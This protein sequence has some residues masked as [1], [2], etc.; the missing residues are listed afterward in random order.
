M[1]A[2]ADRKT[3]SQCGAALDDD[4]APIVEFETDEGTA[5]TC[6]SCAERLVADLPADG[7]SP[8]LDLDPL[9]L[10]EGF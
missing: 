7:E 2:P 3:C 4:T 1:T 9:F 6:L 8:G 10:M 5:A